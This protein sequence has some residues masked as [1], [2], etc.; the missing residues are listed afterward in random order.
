MRFSV[1]EGLN[2]GITATLGIIKKIFA[3]KNIFYLDWKIGL[4][5]RLEGKS[6]AETAEE[7]IDSARL[8]KET[9]TI[10]CSFTPGWRKSDF[11]GWGKQEMRKRI[12]E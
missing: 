12:S 5:N 1:C 4:I 7:G 8:K 9:K 11:R 6:A 2:Y 10:L 3:K